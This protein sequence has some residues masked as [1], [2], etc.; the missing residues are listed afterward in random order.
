MS[1][2][3]FSKG[4]PSAEETGAEF[5]ESRRDQ[6]AGGDEL[7]LKGFPDKAACREYE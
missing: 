4:L 6:A 7:D 5:E 1:D 2:P 3:S